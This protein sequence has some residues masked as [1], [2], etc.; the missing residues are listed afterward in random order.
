VAIEKLRLN[1]ELF[2]AHCVHRGPQF[3][4]V[5]GD[6]RARQCPASFYGGLVKDVPDGPR[7][8]G[9]RVLHPVCLIEHAR[10]EREVVELLPV[11]LASGGIDALIAVLGI[12]L[13]TLLQSN[14]TVTGQSRPLPHRLDVDDDECARIL[15]GLIDDLTALVCTTAHNVWCRFGKPL[16]STLSPMILDAVGTHH[17]RGKSGLPKLFKHAKC[18][19]GLNG[20][21]V[22][23]CPSRPRAEHHLRALE[24]EHQPLGTDRASFGHHLLPEP[25]ARARALST[26]LHLH[27]FSTSAS[28]EPSSRS[29]VRSRTA[30]AGAIRSRRSRH[31]HSLSLGPIWTVSPNTP[32]ITTHDPHERGSVQIFARGSQ[33]APGICLTISFSCHCICTTS[34]TS[35]I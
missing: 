29:S 5:V 21:T 4:R 16:L 22:N 19:Q 31:A 20:L 10:L 1:W 26:N 23:P 25:N 15:F 32:R 14:R 35:T 2:R 17:E 9:L 6:G 11:H 8:L 13:T 24:T 27:D 18:T 30:F 12:A 3:T 33:A 34:R 7:L 28:G